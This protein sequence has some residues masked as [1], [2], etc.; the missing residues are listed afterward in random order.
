MPCRAHGAA[1]AAHLDHD[2]GTPFEP[3]RTEN[4]AVRRGFPEPISFETVVLR[5]DRRCR[6][7]T[8]SCTVSA[9]S[10]PH[11]GS[12]ARRSCSRMMLPGLVLTYHAVCHLPFLS[13]TPVEA[14]HVV[15]HCF[16][17]GVART[18]E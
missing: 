3:V 10:N 7:S 8:I 18:E 4:H 11:S 5:S 6:P 16:Q 2:V 9:R 17:A 12:S 1:A 15:H 13:P 14:V